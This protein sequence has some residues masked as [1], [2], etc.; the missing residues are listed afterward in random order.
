MKKTRRPLHHPYCA[1][2]KWA[3]IAPGGVTAGSHVAADSSI[4][5][6]NVGGFC[7]RSLRFISRCDRATLTQMGLQRE[8]EIVKIMS[9]PPS[10]SAVS[11]Q[12]LQ[13]A[14]LFRLLVASRNK[15]LT[16]FRPLETFIQSVRDPAEL[17]SSSSFPELREAL[18]L[19][20]LFWTQN[21]FFFLKGC[22]KS[23][24]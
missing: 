17:R 12:T 13:Q 16:Y 3:L 4:T 14:H 15:V 5:P 23:L 22:R 11:P 2:E 18:H 1:V 24:R 7:L 20:A 6:G 10:M 8:R 19:L 9:L 21:G